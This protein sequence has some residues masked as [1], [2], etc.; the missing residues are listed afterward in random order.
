MWIKSGLCSADSLINIL[1]CCL[2]YL[3]GLI[4]AWYI[5]ARNP[6]VEY[7]YEPIPE[8]GEPA[9][10][11]RV[12][13]Y[14]ISRQAARNGPRRGGYGTQNPPQQSSQGEGQR[15]NANVNKPVP[16]P[17]Q[18]PQHQG[19]VGAGPSEGQTAPPPS[20]AEVVKGDNKVQSQ[21]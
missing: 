14:Y 12:T 17:P 21:D 8:G 11:D 6:E 5:I 2:G 10:A 9:H 1:L 16:P 15:T 19:D 20:Y 3:P 18:H 7:D 4:H 13:Y